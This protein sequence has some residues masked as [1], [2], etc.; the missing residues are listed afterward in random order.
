MPNMKTKTVRQADVFLQ[1]LYVCSVI[2]FQPFSACYAKA[3]LRWEQKLEICS[4][5]VRVFLDLPD[6][7][8]H[9]LTWNNG[10]NRAVFK[11]TGQ[12]TELNVFHKCKPKTNKDLLFQPCWTLY[13]FV[14]LRYPRFQLWLAWLC[15]RSYCK[16]CNL[17]NIPAH[18]WTSLIHYWKAP[19]ER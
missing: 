14:C 15:V 9:R 19:P 6:R 18:S 17:F 8:V 13:H 2:F 1:P 11:W 7:L 10:A 4:C 16:L 12:P 5:G 3:Y